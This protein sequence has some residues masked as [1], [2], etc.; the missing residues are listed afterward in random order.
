MLFVWL[1]LL[2]SAATLMLSAGADIRHLGHEN[3]ETTKLYTRV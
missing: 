3:L 2:H 1:L